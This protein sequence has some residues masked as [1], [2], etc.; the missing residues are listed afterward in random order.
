MTSQQTTTH[1][2]AL[3]VDGRPMAVHDFLAACARGLDPAAETS[4]ADARLAGWRE[5]L[6]AGGLPAV[7]S[8]GTDAT[9]W[10]QAGLQITEGKLGAVYVELLRLA[11]DLLSGGAANF[12]FMHKPPGLRVRVEAPP[13]LRPR[14]LATVEERTGRWRTGGLVTS[15][16]PACYEPEAHLFGGPVSMTSVHRLFT[17]DSMAWLGFHTSVRPGPAWAF[18]LVLL[19]RLFAALGVVGWE[20]RDVWDRVRRSTGRR[21]SPG[22]RAADGFGRAAEGVRRVWADETA[23][24]ELLAPETQPLIDRYAADVT[25]EAA[26]WRTDYFDTWHAYVGP[27]EA[28]AFAVVFHWNRGG[29][30]FAR[31]AFL[32]EALAS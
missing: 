18:S 10:T 30:P 2:A 19:R 31:Q 6:L 29:L 3:R 32:A 7:R 25:T 15:V 21:L 17:A 13:G 12:F 9:S 5:A 1:P 16:T 11:G 26:R 23:L 20:D 14:M 4:P 22:H 24:R 8:M 27:R 28:A